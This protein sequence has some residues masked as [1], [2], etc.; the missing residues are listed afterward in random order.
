MS[1]QETMI[2]AVGA[3]PACVNVEGV[4]IAAFQSEQSLFERI[5]LEI[6][7]PQQALITYVNAHVLNTA[8]RLPKLKR[9]LTRADVVYCDGAGIQW[10]ARLAGQ[11]LPRRLPAADWFLSF[12]RFMAKE[13]L[14]IYL[15]GGEP[16][17]A[18][19]MLALLNAVAPRHSVIGFHHGYFVNDPA[20]E[21]DVIDEINRLKPD[22]LIVGLGTP[23]QEFWVDK[24]RSQIDVGAILPLGAVMDYFTGRQPRCPQWMGDAGFEWLY[25][26]SSEPRR[27]MGRYLIGNPWFMGRAC[28]QAAPHRLRSIFSA[29]GHN[30]P[31]PFRL[32]RAEMAR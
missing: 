4:T 25:R 19:K 8:F 14:S 10:A 13:R 15:L 5:A 7:K 2:S 31:I 28:L 20:Q 3:Y 1:V 18:E 22:L 26:F 24:R 32:F 17:I 16:G 23:I 27:L 11:W 6:R 21:R 30:R 29:D 12:F 9:F